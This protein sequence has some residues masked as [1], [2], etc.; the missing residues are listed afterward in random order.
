MVVQLGENHVRKPEDGF[1]LDKAH[2][3][4]DRFSGVAGQFL[5][6][7]SNEEKRITS[8]MALRASSLF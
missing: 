8:L 3:R 2:E 7:S 5:I 1:S 6:Y 4:F